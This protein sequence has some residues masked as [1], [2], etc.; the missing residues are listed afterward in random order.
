VPEPA[1][2]GEARDV[3][4]LSATGKAGPGPD[5]E[6]LRRQADEK[7]RRK[8]DGILSDYAENA[9]R[10]FVDSS[11]EV[12]P[13]GSPLAGQFVEALS[14][15][16]VSRVLTQHEPNRVW[17]VA[18]MATHV[19][20]RVE[21]RHANEL[22]VELLPGV[23]KRLDPFDMPPQAAASRL[24]TFLAERDR[25]LLAEELESRPNTGANA[26]VPGVPAW[27]RTGRHPEYP[28]GE[29]F[30]EVGL[31]ETYVQAQQEAFRGIAEQVI[32]AMTARAAKVVEDHPEAP[33]AQ[34]L[35]SIDL[36][37]IPVA[38]GDLEATATFARWYDPVTSVHYVFCVADRER[39]A[40][41]HVAACRKAGGKSRELLESSA[42]H[43]KAGNFT[44]ALVD[45]MEAA[46]AARQ[47][48]LEQ[49]LALGA[50]PPDGRERVLA[51]LEEP[52]LPRARSRAQALLASVDLRVESGDNQ[53]TPPGGNPPQPLVVRVTATDESLPVSAMPLRFR[54]SGP[55]GRDLG[56]VRTDEDGLA[57]LKL[58]NGTDVST[59]VAEPAL[60]QL[61]PAAS[62]SGPY[63][64]PG[65]RFELVLRSPANIRFAVRVIEQTG[66]MEI[67]PQIGPALRQALRDMGYEVLPARE[68]RADVIALE[69]MEA[70]KAEDV[71]RV[72]HPIRQRVEPEGFLVVV[73]GRAQTEHVRDL[74]NDDGAISI[75]H[76]PYTV[77]VYDPA[78]A[79][80]EKP[81]MELQG[82]GRGAYTDRP[83]EA[84]ERALMDAAAQAAEQIE[85]KA[86]EVLGGVD[87]R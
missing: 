46:D 5:T 35:E 78:G 4:F 45:A 8:L 63:V 7:A 67:A 77:H 16:L 6:K 49:C 60:Q 19:E 87:K 43:D 64:A 72:F 62:S 55:G 53:W 1:S 41:A 37:G 59:I 22:L 29:F 69:G 21:R 2:S 86:D 66:E 76:C 56:V 68:I 65:A 38:V 58:T 57:R 33:L 12:A 70:P 61:T 50:V 31:A 82:K 34:N 26:G 79:T 42:N 47:A 71:L 83:R 30:S 75:W 84:A 80:P 81:I 73:F 23:A 28:P 74:P 52:L 48:V 18:D 51:L 15:E 27:V 3:R 10:S 20:Y 25:A 32:S 14:A 36:A 24:E 39:T 11:S 44:P 17:R 13:S 54:T 9:L 85:E 40:S